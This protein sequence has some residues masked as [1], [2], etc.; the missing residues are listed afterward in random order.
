MTNID[1][2]DIL[3]S[4]LRAV[5]TEI[6]EIKEKTTSNMLS[7]AADIHKLEQRLEKLEKRAERESEINAKM[8]ADIPPERMAEIEEYAK[9]LGITTHHTTKAHIKFGENKK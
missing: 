9:K 7:I 8:A 3:R 1:P 2:F 4:N 5:F 6:D